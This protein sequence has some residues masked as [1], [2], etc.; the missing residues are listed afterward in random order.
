M[1]AEPPAVPEGLPALVADVGL[2]ARVDAEVPGERPRVAEAGVAD[3]AGVG[4]LPGVNALVDLQV[5][6]AVEV[7]AAQGAVVGAAARGEDLAFGVLRGGGGRPGGVDVVLGAVFP[8]LPGQ[9]EGL[10]ADPADVVVPDGGGHLGVPAA[11]LAGEGLVARDRDAAGLPGLVRFGERQ[12]H[13]AGRGRE[14]IWDL[15]IEDRR[16]SCEGVHE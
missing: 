3:G 16:V 8:Q 10:A 12:R 1:E 9:L 7:P 5:L 11:H 15:W 2:L 6:H 14:D 4:P 13:A